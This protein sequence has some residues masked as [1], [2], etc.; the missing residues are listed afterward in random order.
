MFTITGTLQNIFTTP[1]GKGKDGSEY[2]STVK[3]QIM[4]E[5]ILKSGGKKIEL[6][7]LTL[8]PNLVTE[9]TESLGT[10]VTWPCGIFVSG[11]K[12]TPFLTA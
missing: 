3:A 10:E 4:G 9:A 12:I 6:L 2:A 5:T 7:T 11:G 1:A 8:P